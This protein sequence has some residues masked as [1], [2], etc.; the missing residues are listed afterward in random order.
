MAVK[1]KTDFRDIKLFGPRVQRSFVKQMP[2]VLSR[3]IKEDI[4]SGL[5]P[6]KGAGVY[7]KYSKDYGRR[8]KGRR[9]PVDLFLSGK[10]LNSLK[11]SFSRIGIL[12]VEFTDKKAAF[13]NGND[14]GKKKQGAK[15]SNG[16]P[17]RRMLPDR[18][19]EQFNNGIR[20]TIDRLL[21]RI[22]KREVTKQNR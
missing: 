3:E 21:D 17:V 12:T 4:A 18:R 1:V 9:R 20:K 19:G 11:I 6:V 22:I 10:L 13:H 2:K 14:A 15:L 8:V 5:S 16:L 7:P